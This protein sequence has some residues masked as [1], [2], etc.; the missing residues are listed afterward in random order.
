MD[1][2]SQQNFDRIVALEP[3]AWTAG[4]IEFMK[5]REAYLSADQR[6]QFGEVLG[7]EK[8]KAAKKKD[9]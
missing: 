7:F 5:A 6:D 4:D 1:T 9:E 3:A 8:P 2:Q